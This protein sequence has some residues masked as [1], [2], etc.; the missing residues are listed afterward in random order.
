MTLTYVKP[1]QI[2]LKGHAA[3][4]EKWLQDVIAKDTSVLGL[5]E[6]EIVERERR[7]ERAGRLD[8][9]LYDRQQ[10]LRYEVELMLGA[11]DESHII[12]AIEY[13]DIERRRYPGYDHCAVL[14][15]EDITSRFLNVLSLFAGT[16]P[17]VAIQLSALQV[18]EQI[19]LNFVRVLDRTSLRRDDE[20]EVVSTPAKREDWIERTSPQMVSMVDGFIQTINAKAKVK[21]Q[22]NYTKTYIGLSDGNKA[23][24]YVYF[25]PRKKYVYIYAG[26]GEPAGWVAKLEEA[27]ITSGVY[28]YNEFV[29]AMVR[30]DDLKNNHEI[31]TDLLHQAVSNYES[32]Q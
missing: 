24:N 26:A 13:W 22:S 3:F 30:P 15:A 5:G 12:R 10:N 20:V 8:L 2:H 14:V 6:L 21:V 4:N 17:F 7:Q 29:W 9:M 19:A 11:T 23:S 25:I 32:T 1:T 18:G 16:I 27:G 28:A 31:V